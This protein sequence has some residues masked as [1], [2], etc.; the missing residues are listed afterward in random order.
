[1]VQASFRGT[2]SQAEHKT[3][4]S[5]TLSNGQN[6]KRSFANKQLHAGFHIYVSMN[7]FGNVS[8]HY[9]FQ[10]IG[11]GLFTIIKIISIS[12]K[13]WFGLI[14]DSK[15]SFLCHG[16]MSGWVELYYSDHRSIWFHIWKIR[17]HEATKHLLDSKSLE[18]CSWNEF[19]F[20]FSLERHVSANAVKGICRKPAS[21]PS[22][23]KKWGL[24]TLFLTHP[25]P[26]SLWNM[27]DL[28]PSIVEAKET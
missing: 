23:P 20:T 25:W 10:F 12:W 1:M 11:D 7:E 5:S 15:T 6:W 28:N 2:W 14:L 8:S 19:A 21:D 3:T 4:E 16:A 18:G 17:L 26:V 13:V 9:L 22:W 24:F 27:P